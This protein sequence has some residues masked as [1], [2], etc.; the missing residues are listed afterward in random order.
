MLPG[1][2]Y[3]IKQKL[4]KATQNSQQTLVVIILN[5]YQRYLDGNANRRTLKPS[6]VCV[7]TQVG[8]E[9]LYGLLAAKSRDD[10]SNSA[11]L[12]LVI[13]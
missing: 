9:R 4:V 2:R 3:T 12:L 8:N 6:I 5:S 13:L 10:T 1:I 11:D 7:K